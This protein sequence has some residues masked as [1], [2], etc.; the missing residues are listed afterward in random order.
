M[1]LLRRVARSSR[2]LLAFAAS[3]PFLAGCVNV[4]GVDDRDREQHRLDRAWDRFESVAPLSYTYTVRV[5]CECPHDVTRPVSVWVD[6]GVVEYLFYEDNGEAVPFS[7][8]NW[9]PSAEELFDEIQDALYREADYLEVDYDQTYGY[10][11]NV[12]IDYDRHIAD[13]EYSIVTWGLRRWD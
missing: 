8:A 5:S 2:S 4:T 11:T 9:F 6:R 1:S 13:E 7:Y 10:P 12:F 3:L